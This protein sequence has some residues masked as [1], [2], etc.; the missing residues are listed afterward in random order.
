MTVGNGPAPSGL[1]SCACSVPPL[2]G[3]S[4]CCGAASGAA[5]AADAATRKPKDMSVESRRIVPPF[6][7]RRK[8]RTTPQIYH[9]S[10]AENHHKSVGLTGRLRDL[11]MVGD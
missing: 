9:A 6:A 10:R 4:T 2:E 3:I 7:G 5:I 8:H 1:N 11:C